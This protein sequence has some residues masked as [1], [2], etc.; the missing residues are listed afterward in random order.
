[1]SLEPSKSLESSKG[2]EPE[3]FCRRIESF[4][5]RKNDGHLVRIVGPAFEQVCDW[6]RR[7]VPLAVAQHGIDRYF[8]RY[9]A[10]GAR[11]RPVRIEFCEADV[12]DAFDEWRRALGVSLQEGT[13]DAETGEVGR[14]EGARAGERVRRQVTLAAHLERVIARLTA[15]RSG[16]ARVLDGPLDGIVRELDGMRATANGLRGQAREAV[17]QRLLALDAQLIEAARGLGDAGSMSALEREADLELS[18][19]RDRM[20]APAYDRS[21]RACVDRLLRE[22]H[23]LP[24]ISFE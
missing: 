3:E 21:R 1:M 19:F 23:R 20:L 4:L 17:L 24:V 18:P 8:E 13:G 15:A 5:C 12:L 11:R 16:E 10:K 22:R 7:G 9:Y 14:A 2:L 6:C